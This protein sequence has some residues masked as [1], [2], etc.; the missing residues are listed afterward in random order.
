M[1]GDY[2]LLTQVSELLVEHVWKKIVYT[3]AM[4]IDMRSVGQASVVLGLVRAAAGRQSKLWSWYR[5]KRTLGHRIGIERTRS[6]GYQ[7]SGQVA[8]GFW[9]NWLSETPA[10]IDF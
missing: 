1:F 5:R 10:L 3:D 9:F 8:Q 4:I 7:G 6:S 2:E